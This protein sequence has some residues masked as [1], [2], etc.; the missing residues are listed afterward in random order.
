MYISSVA[1]VLYYSNIYWRGGEQCPRGVVDKAMSSPCVNGPSLMSNCLLII[2]VIGSCVV[3][4]FVPQSRNYVHFR[5]KYPWERY[6]PPYPS[7]F[8]LN[9]TTTVLGEWYVYMLCT[10]HIFMYGYVTVYAD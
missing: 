8:A 1:L 4:E 6:E 5:G 2:L 9:S 7:F 10:F 3:S